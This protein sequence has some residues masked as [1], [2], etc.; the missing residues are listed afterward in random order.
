MYNGA[1]VYVNVCVCTCAVLLIFA[2]CVWQSP[3]P[4]TTRLESTLNADWRMGGPP[5]SRSWDLLVWLP[6][7]SQH[8]AMTDWQQASFPLLCFEGWHQSHSWT[9]WWCRRSK[10]SAGFITNL[11]KSGT[12]F[13]IHSA[14]MSKITEI[15]RPDVCK[16]GKMHQYNSLLHSFCLQHKL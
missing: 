15:S 5:I 10:V 3:W 12:T 1:F 7:L 14:Y 9:K 2:S 4:L 13:G 16:N 6:S 8:S 11:A